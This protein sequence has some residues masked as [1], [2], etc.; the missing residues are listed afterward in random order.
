MMTM[1]MMVMTMTMMTSHEP[2]AG[3]AAAAREGACEGRATRL[4]D[5]PREGA[6]VIIV[7]IVIIAISG[8]RVW[9]TDPE[10]GGVWRLA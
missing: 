9:T 3:G 10:R 1:V 4:D 2:E 5:G 7:S 8:R 6:V